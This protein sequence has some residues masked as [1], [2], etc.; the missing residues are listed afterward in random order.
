MD[1]TCINTIDCKQGAVRAVRFN[2]DGA[3]CLTCGSDK[4]LKLWNPYRSL[5]LKTYGGHA[6]EVLDA[7]GSCDSGQILSCSSDKSIILW[8]VSTGQPLRRLR[9]HASAVCCVKFNEEST[10]AI[11][12]S[13]DN[14]V[15]IWDLKSRKNEPIQILNEAKDCINAIQVTD[16]EIITGSVDCSVR[17]YDIRAGQMFADF[18]GAP[19]TSVSLTHDGQCILISAADNSVKLFDKTT[20]EMLAEYIGHRTDDMNVESAVITNDNYVFSGSITG[21]LWCWDLISAKVVKRYDHTLH[22]VLHSVAVHPRKDILLTASVN[23]IKVWGKPEDI[24]VYSNVQ[25]EDT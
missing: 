14:T 17:R 6:N 13:H 11:S 3:Y 4:K 9:T 5:L 2:V 24:V 10:L 16:Y 20:G 23:T 25:Y 7:A 21:E 19:I 15:A 12:G 8:D 1:L 22:K 18:V